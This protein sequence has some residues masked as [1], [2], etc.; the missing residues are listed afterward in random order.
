MTV[1]T[2]VST[3]S[4]VGNGA[5]TV[6]TYPFYIITAEHLQVWVNGALLP[7]TGYTVT[8]VGNQFGGEVTLAV[9]P[10]AGE[11]LTLRRSVP[12]TQLVD[13]RPFDPFPAETHEQALDK[14]TM[15]AQEEAGFIANS[16]RAP[17]LEPVG[18][19]NLVLPYPAARANSILGFDLAGN[20]Q[21]L[22]PPTGVPGPG[23]TDHGA[24]TGLADDDHP[25]YLK[26]LDAA[27]GYLPLTG[28]TLTGALRLP[29]AFPTL[30]VEAANKAYVDTFTGSVITK[31]IVSNA[32]GDAQGTVQG[33]WNAQANASAITRASNEIIYYRWKSTDTIV[34]RYVGSQQGPAGW[35][36]IASDWAAASG[37]GEAPLDGNIYGRIGAAWAQ[38]VARSGGGYT[39]KVQGF[40]GAAAA[41]DLARTDEVMVLDAAAIAGHVALLDP[42]NQYL[43]KADV[44]GTIVQ[45]PQPAGMKQG[46]QW[47]ESDTGMF[48]MRYVNPDATETLV[49]LAA[50]GGDFIPMSMRGAANGVASLDATTKVPLAQ[51]PTLPFLSGQVLQ[52]VTVTDAGNS[53]SSTALANFN[54]V[55]V[56]IV[57]KS[58]SSKILVQVTF[59]AQHIGIA[60]TPTFSTFRL[61]DFTSSLDIGAGE[62][63]QANQPTPVPAITNIV[64]AAIAAAVSNA[65]LTARQFVLRGRVNNAGTIVGAFKMQWVLTE[66]QN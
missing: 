17:V 56:T 5:S 23:I 20:I 63:V 18:S 19:T 55:A 7:V 21:L 28:G 49:A 46:Q 22:P 24:L 12:A 58:A 35:A 6:F 37:V 25:Q 40:A 31:N 45:D 66:I 52:V 50:A 2:L 41:A 27:A 59:E 60:G 32:T 47:Y 38:V 57:P 11:N 62:I 53:H 48:A 14:L 42:H 29:S 26:T 9:A 16:I 43:L 34:Y 30:P 10:L 13:Y 33:G 51:L 65:V 54:G 64:P 3:V 36:T 1:A 15:I 4:Y 44:T 8:G 39:G 61:F